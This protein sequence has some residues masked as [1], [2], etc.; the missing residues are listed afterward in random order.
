MFSSLYLDGACR[1]LVWSTSHGSQLVQRLLPLV[2]SVRSV[3]QP[4]WKR[5]GGARSES[6]LYSHFHRLKSGQLISK[7]VSQFTVIGLPTLSE[8]VLQVVVFELFFTN[9]TTTKRRQFGGVSRIAAPS[10]PADHYQ[11][12]TATKKWWASIHLI[13]QYL[14]DCA[15]IILGKR[16]I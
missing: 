9:A 15:S 7:S 16:S 2:H 5:L 6:R 11:R 8:I 1:H 14:L 10:T 13:G 3:R 4:P 12:E